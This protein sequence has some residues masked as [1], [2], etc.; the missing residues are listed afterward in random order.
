MVYL[1]GTRTY[2]AKKEDIDNHNKATNAHEN[3][4]GVL[5]NLKT[6]EKTNLAGSINEVYENNFLLNKS[7][8]D[9][10]GIFTIVKYMRSNGKLFLVSTLYG[11]SSPNYTNRKL[12]YYNLDGVTIYKTINRTL[13][14]DTD[15]DFV[16]EV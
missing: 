11:G 8:K 2:I 5:S 1:N 15:G 16:S 3:V 10:N 4:I 6:T 14:Y 7:A 9:E 12:E 13:S